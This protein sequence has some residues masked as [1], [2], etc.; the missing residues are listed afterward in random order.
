MNKLVDVTEMVISLDEVHNA[1]NLKNRK[2]S[3]T[4]F[5]YHVTAYEDFEPYFFGITNLKM[6]SSFLQP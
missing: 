6:A 4:L 2:P 1:N 5:M 3:N